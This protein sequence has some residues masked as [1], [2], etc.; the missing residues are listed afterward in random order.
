MTSWVKKLNPASFRG[1]RF[2]VLGSEQ[3]FGRRVAVHE[4]PNRDKPFVEDMGR[5]TRSI[6]LVGFLIE[7]SHVYGGGSVLEQR[8][9][10][11]A[12]AE[13]AGPG[14]LIHP[15]LGQLTVS[16]PDGGLSVVERW[17]E[18]RYF[19]LHFSFIEAGERVFPAAKVA[20]KSLLDSLV[21][22]LGLAGLSDFVRSVEATISSV[23]AAI[24]TVE[25]VISDTLDTVESVISIGQSAVNAVIDT[26]AGFQQMAGRITH[27]VSN[28]SSLGSLLTGDF[29][30]YTSGAT[31]KAFQASPSSSDTSAAMSTLIASGCAKRAAVASASASL[32]AAAAGLNAKTVGV[33]V[34]AV[35][36]LVDAVVAA[37]PSP[38]DRIRL[39]SGLASFM[40]TA[41]S[42]TSPMGQAKSVAQF[43]TAALIR[44]SALG[45]LASAVSEYTPSSYDDTLA[46]RNAVVGVLDAELLIAGDMGD[47]A[48]YVALNSL[49]QAIVVDLDTRGA[50][51]ASLATFALNANLPAL[52]LANR[53]Y[54]DAGRSDELIGEA[55]PIHPAF[56][57]SSFRALAR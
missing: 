47:D 25:G 12:A 38:A 6:N 27:D 35:N 19:E 53:L 24:K 51:L 18:G 42:S 34:A 2:G 15:T 36:A 56:M 32:T 11:I 57:P 13:K 22:K 20:T 52:V 44:R 5:S 8:E 40:P 9:L 30:R 49:R 29:G 50:T 41:Y 4:Y 28:I 39:L 10:M 1:L 33:F 3:R 54:Q 37:I 31:T 16:L 43:V 26:V 21:D 14:I 46:V 55:D 7:D 23:F 48:T 17:D 45:A